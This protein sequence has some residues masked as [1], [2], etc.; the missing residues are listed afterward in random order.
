[1]PK[2][3]VLTDARLGE[4]NLLYICMVDTS[5]AEYSPVSHKVTN[6]DI[7]SIPMIKLSSQYPTLYVII[8]DRVYN[9]NK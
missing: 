9:T 8:C 7:D 5:E 1:M 4:S 3:K 6:R 2:L